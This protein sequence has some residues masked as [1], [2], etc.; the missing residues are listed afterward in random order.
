MP[1]FAPG[2][3]GTD[4]VLFAVDET[5]GPDPAQP[6]PDHQ[7]ADPRH[8]RGRP[9]T[10]A[11]SW[12]QD[13]TVSAVTI[14]GA[15]ERGLCAGGDVRAVREA[16]LAGTSGGVDFWADEYVLDAQI[17]EYPK[18]VIALMDGIVMGGGLG[19]SMF[20]DARWAT[21]R[22]RVAMPE[23]IIGFFPDVAATYLLSRA[24]GR[25]GPTSR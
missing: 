3:T 1:D 11:R 20:A 17:A 25:R 19:I 23:T 13:D 5:P 2:P 22:S 10:A 6:A 12:E 9:R 14:E 4:E 16:H 24:P 15:G 21:E 8:G 18:P 7:L